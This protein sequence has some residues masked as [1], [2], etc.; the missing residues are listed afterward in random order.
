MGRLRET[1]KKY[2]IFRYPYKSLRFLKNFGVSAAVKRAKEK[3]DERAYRIPESP[4]AESVFADAVRSDEKRISDIAPMGEL[5]GTIAVRLCFSDADTF[6]TALSYLNHIPYAFDLYA[7]YSGDV[8]PHEAKKH[9]SKL[10]SGAKIYLKKLNGKTCTTAELY[11]ALGR[12]LAGY[13]YILNL[14]MIRAGEDGC[15]PS[16]SNTVLSALLGSED[17]I[18]RLFGLLEGDPEAGMIY[19]ESDS[20]DFI[21]ECTWARFGQKG[22]ELSEKLGV[23]FEEGF[24]NCPAGGSFIAKSAVLKSLFETGFTAEE[25]AGDAFASIVDHILPSCASKAGMRCLPLDHER[26]TVHFGKSLKAFREYFGSSAQ[27]LARQISSD[28][29]VISFDI[30]DTLVSFAVYRPQDILAIAQKRINEEPGSKAEFVRDRLLAGKAA[31]EKYGDKVSIDDIYG[32]LASAAGIS[33]EEAERWKEIEIQ[34]VIDMAVPRKDIVSLMN[35]FIDQ[36]KQVNLIADTHLPADVIKRII[37]KCGGLEGYGL[38]LS[39]ETGRSKDKP[40]FWDA[41]ASEHN[42]SECFHFGD[43]LNSDYIVPTRSGIDSFLVMNPRD[44]YMLSEYY[45]KNGDASEE[46]EISVL[47]G[48]FISGGMF[49]S[50]FAFE[51][52]T[53][54]LKTWYFEDNVRLLAEK[55]FSGEKFEAYSGH[56]WDFGGYKICFPKKTPSYADKNKNV[57]VVVHEMLRSGAP[58]VT[59]DLADIIRQFGYNVVIASPSD[60]PL[61]EELLERG[62]P[63]FALPEIMQGIG[64]DAANGSGYDMV[65]TDSVIKNMNMSVF[66]TIVLYNLIYRYDNTENKIVWWLHESKES[67]AVWGKHMTKRVGKNVTVLAVCEYVK[68]RLEE[69]GLDYAPGILMYGAPDFARDVKKPERKDDIVRFACVGGIEKRKAQDILLEAIKLL[70]FEYLKRMDFTFAGKVWQRDVFQRLEAFDRSYPNVH[71]LGAI[72]REKVVEL[73]ASSDCVVAPSRDD[74]MP[75][76]M[77]EGMIVSDIC[78]CSTGAGTTDY[79]KDGE[80]GFVFKNED[81]EDLK[82]KLIYIVDNIDRLED[83]KRESRKIYDTYFSMDVFKDNIRKMLEEQTG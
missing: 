54:M 44:L 64:E 77:T 11:G 56:D 22:R 59:V 31:Y 61:R 25:A 55:V 27:S 28:Y 67:F 39:N 10:R 21:E 36:G 26:D 43:D 41:Y 53:G 24:Y 33:E 6:E 70:P 12:K 15:D 14:D 50:P 18:R 62:F 7:S 35:V 58:I 80:S 45:A 79:M 52:Y 40:G 78:V 73:F 5:N 51:P 81:P 2:K 3:L 69:Y 68:R 66:S 60:G 49:N 17:R 23:K 37:Y 46:L 65:I 13:H 82:N 74:P 57:L 30:F 42:V 83:I 8:K 32:E 20:V 4:F 38:I 76:V 19:P 72:P 47:Y 29:K 34:S 1:A 9:A 16:R 75:V 71:Y 63:V 48:L